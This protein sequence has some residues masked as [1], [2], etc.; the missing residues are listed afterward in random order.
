MGRDDYLVSLADSMQSQGEGE[1]IGAGCD[2]HDVS[3]PQ[4]CSDRAFEL[5]YFRPQDERPVPQ[6]NTHRLQ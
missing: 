4:A 6:H 1:R 2:C 5:S 3:E